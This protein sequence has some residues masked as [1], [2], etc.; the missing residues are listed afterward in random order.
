VLNKAS[1][2]SIP[3][4]HGFVHLEMHLPCLFAIYLIRTND[5]L[6][7]EYWIGFMAKAYGK[8][9][10]YVKVIKVIKVILVIKVVSFLVKC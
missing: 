1:N 3:V 5:Y 8:H 9:M 4:I 7:H 10:P 2:Y 6:I